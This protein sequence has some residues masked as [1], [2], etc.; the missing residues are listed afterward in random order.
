MTR[1][2]RTV[3]LLLAPTATLT[4]IGFALLVR[5]TP[6]AL[7]QSRSQPLVTAPDAVETCRVGRHAWVVSTRDRDAYLRDY[8][9]VMRQ[10]VLRPHAGQDPD[11]VTDLSIAAI[12][13]ESPMDAAGFRKDDRIVQVNGTPI[14]TLGRAANL[15]HEIKACERLSIQ[16]RRGD[17]IIDY[18]FDFQ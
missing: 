15:V 7:H 8:A 6:A 1:G 11:S 10:M 3:L 16:V 12:S 18:R 14:R 17:Q 5:S 13:E 9:K 2:R 4:L